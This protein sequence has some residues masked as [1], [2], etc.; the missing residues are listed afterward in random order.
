MAYATKAD[1]IDRFGLQ[2]LVQLTDRTLVPPTTVD[3]TVVG[4]ALDDATSRIDG[5]LAKVYAVPL[6]TV[7]P[8]VVKIA[9]DIARYD[10]HGKRAGK[11]DQVTRAYAEAVKWLGDVSR[12]LVRLDDGGAAPIPA[13][14]GGGRV[15][16]SEPVFT[17]D[18][19]A[20]F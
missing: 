19:L 8:I 17:R 11:D 20:G 13:T 2:E 18:T 6:A 15:S 12:G 5:Y 4:R 7:P 3:D 14:G 1:L 9:A 16:G 10:L